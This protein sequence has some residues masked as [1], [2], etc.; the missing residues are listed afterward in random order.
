MSQ[1]EILNV[2]KEIVVELTAKANPSHAKEFSR[3]RTIVDKNITADS[4]LASLGWD[5]LQMTFLLVALEERLGINTST[6]SMFDLYS[7]GD[8][9]GELQTQVN[10]RRQQQGDS[11][12]YR[13]RCESP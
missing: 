13:Y 10:N 1:D 3:L 2:L 11:H 6:I 7:V 12:R 5:S 4:P 9:L 8:F